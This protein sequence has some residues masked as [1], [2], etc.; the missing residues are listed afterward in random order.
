METVFSGIQPTGGFHI[1]NLLGAVQNW[2]AL[3][4]RYRC[5]Y[6]IVDLHALTQE[7]ETREMA[8][9][10]Q[11]MTAEPLASGLD[12]SRCTIFVQ[13]HVHEHSELAWVLNSVTSHGELERMTQF[14]DK[15]ARAEFINAGIFNYPILMAADI[16]LYKA[17]RVPV[18][19]DQVQH[20][21]LAREIAR[22]FNARFGELFPEPLPLH[23][24]AL[25][26]LGLDGKQKMSKSLGNT[27]QVA[28]PPDVIRTKI[29]NAFTDPTR[30]RKSDPGH[31]DA[32][33]VCSLQG[34]FASAEETAEMHRKCA[35]SAWGCVD[36]KRALAENMIRFLAP[37]RERAAEWSAR[38]ER[39]R[40]VLGD[41]AATA[42]AV[43]A[44]TMRQVRERLGL[45]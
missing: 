20:L 9:R 21:E 22:R 38:P 2:V 4:D 37:I 39:I 29:G 45:W 12:P 10:V 30:L 36:S 23:A 42:R 5:F 26:I 41:G 25:K 14:K 11:A 15:S 13:S 44:E 34:Y 1:G 31:P 40:E 3:T 33:Y 27:V 43:A 32:C 17:T 16:L 19:A 8:P 28:D 18:G 35:T 6:C 24:K 7:Y